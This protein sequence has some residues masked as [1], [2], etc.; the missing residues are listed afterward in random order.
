MI[1]QLCLEIA[2]V[3]LY[4]FNWRD[5]CRR[6]GP[7]HHR[8]EVGVIISVTTCTANMVA[9]KGSLLPITIFSLLCAAP[10]VH[11]QDDDLG[12]SNGYITLATQNFDLKLVRD[13]QVLASLNAS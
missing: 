11:A 9:S 12:L 7:P 13:A 6:H 3:W 10:S 2:R 8:I 4:Y 5:G 1:H